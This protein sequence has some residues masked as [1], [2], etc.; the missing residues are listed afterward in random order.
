M[1]IDTD[2]IQGLYEW[3]MKNAPQIYKT[4]H[5]TLGDD[6][7]FY[8]ADGKYYNF[9]LGDVEV[10]YSHD[11]IKL[12]IPNATNFADFSVD[13]FCRAY[14]RKCDKAILDS[15]NKKSEEHKK[16]E[17]KRFRKKIRDLQNNE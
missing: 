17:I 6:V 15:F 13:S 14:K 7:S 1:K 8:F 12:K 9:R 3:V 11:S 4:E 2:K 16:S 5:H 10:G